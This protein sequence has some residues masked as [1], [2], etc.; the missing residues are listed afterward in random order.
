MGRMGLANKFE[1]VQAV[2][3]L[4]GLTIAEINRQSIVSMVLLTFVNSIHLL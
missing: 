1:E 2:L 4:F 3:V